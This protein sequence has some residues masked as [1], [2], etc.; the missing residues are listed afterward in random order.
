VVLWT[1]QDG[2]PHAV[3][4]ALRVLVCVGAR[5]VHT[6]QLSHVNLQQL[7]RHNNNYDLYLYKLWD[8]NK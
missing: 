4:Q 7:Q 2:G 3:V 6:H 8:C 1:R 5:E